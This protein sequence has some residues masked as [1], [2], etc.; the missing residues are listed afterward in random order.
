VKAVQKSAIEFYMVSSYSPSRSADYSK[1][2][3]SRFLT[4]EI[5]VYRIEIHTNRTI[6]SG[7]R[8]IRLNFD[9]L[10]WPNRLPPHHSRQN[11]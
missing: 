1:S 9:Y 3:L 8:Y 7:A 6:I 10:I 5:C 4:F 2:T 11:L